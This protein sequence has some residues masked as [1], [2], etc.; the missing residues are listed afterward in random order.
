M[1]IKNTFLK[2]LLKVVLFEGVMLIGV[3]VIIIT[4]LLQNHYGNPYDGAGVNFGSLASWSHSGILNGEN[5]VTTMFLVVTILTLIFVFYKYFKK[6]DLKI[7]K[8]ITLYVVLSA[9]GLIFFLMM[10]LIIYGIIIG[11]P[12]Y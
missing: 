6:T 8:K 12:F 1:E 7:V 2:S 9:S 11:N 3:W 5:G 4:Q 10:F